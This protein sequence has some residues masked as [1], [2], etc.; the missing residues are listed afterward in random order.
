MSFLFNINF[1]FKTF[2]CPSFVDRRSRKAHPKAAQLG[3]SKKVEGL[4][5]NLK[6]RIAK[7]ET[8]VVQQVSSEDLSL[9]ARLDELE[10][11]EA[12]NAEL[13]Q[14]W[15]DDFDFKESKTEIGYAK[16]DDERPAL[17]QTE[18]TNQAKK[19]VTWETLDNKNDTVVNSSDSLES[20]NDNGDEDIQ[21]T[22]S[23]RFSSSS[24]SL[25]VQVN[26]SLLC[27]SW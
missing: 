9:F 14:L 25:K 22:I 27:Q 23:V 5:S 26:N 2:L 1:F 18:N 11:K 21:R 13:D 16:K 8:K 24:T 4:K 17:T 10:E 20:D 6:D 15:Q 12:E 3:G 19:K 7:K